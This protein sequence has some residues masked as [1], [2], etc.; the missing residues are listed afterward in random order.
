MG[1]NATNSMYEHMISCSP[2]RKNM[3]QDAINKTI[4]ENYDLLLKLGD[5]DDE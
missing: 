4:D 3:I 5:S 2:R 1:V